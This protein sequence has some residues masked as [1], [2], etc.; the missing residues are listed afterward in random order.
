MN[1][2]IKSIFVNDDVDGFGEMYRSTGNNP[3]LVI[4]SRGSSFLHLATITNSK[5]IAQFLVDSGAN[6]L[7]ANDSGE[8]PLGIVEVLKHNDIKDIYLISIYPTGT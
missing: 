6:P 5:R 2:Y 8:P 1:D 4:N 3:S 7:Q